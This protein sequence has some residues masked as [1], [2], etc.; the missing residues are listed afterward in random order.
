MSG[1]MI[2]RL[3]REW[4]NQRLTGG[5]FLFDDE[6]L[7]IGHIERDG[8]YCENYNTGNG[9]K[10]P[11][12]FFTGFKIFQYPPLGYR[13]YGPGLC[14]WTSK[15]HSWQRGLR[16][17]C[18]E[19]EYSPVT[20]L[21]QQYARKMQGAF[22]MPPILELVFFP[23]YDSVDDLDKLFNG[24]VASVVL[25]ENVLIEP[26]IVNENAD[27]YVIYF[28]RRPCATIDPNK[29]KIHWHSKAYEEAL[30]PIFNRGQR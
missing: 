4:C 29:H 21:L 30:S 1:N 18:I 28:K 12:E 11:H 13:K 2:E 6:I 15:K 14:V 9:K 25:N 17:R 7:R 22:N 10:L 5:H 24:D 8:V 3:G 23:K 19:A 26:N 16:E 27:G 20:S